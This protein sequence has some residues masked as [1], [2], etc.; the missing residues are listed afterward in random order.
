ME[1]PEV[2]LVDRA[3]DRLD[4]WLGDDPMDHID[5]LGF[6]QAIEGEYA[7]TSNNFMKNHPSNTAG[8][9]NMLVRFV[10]QLADRFSDLTVPVPLA[11]NSSVAT[12]VNTTRAAHSSLASSD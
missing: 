11:R 5:M 1:G 6:L 12:S 2:G 8:L 9:K 7:R 4:E 10:D 3:I